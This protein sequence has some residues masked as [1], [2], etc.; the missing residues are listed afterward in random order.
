M[1]IKEFFRRWKQ[2]I[3]TLPP[4]QQ[5]KAKITGIKGAVFGMILGFGIMAYQG[6]YW[7]LVLGFFL[8]WLQVIEYIG[9][10]QQYENA[11][12]MEK[13]LKGDKN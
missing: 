2:G 6:N 8:V 10:K 7:F 4:S 11:V 12:I 9:T 3:L 5:L 1:N 13:E